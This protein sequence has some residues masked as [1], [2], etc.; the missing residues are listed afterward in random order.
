MNMFVANDECGTSYQNIKKHLT[1][2]KVKKENKVKKK[3]KQH[4]NDVVFHN[5]DDH[6]DE[7]NDDVGDVI[8]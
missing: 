5:N 1:K 3:T 6:Y 8:L 2:R 7:R 4:R